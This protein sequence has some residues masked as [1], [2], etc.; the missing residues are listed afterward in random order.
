M[1]RI[2]FLLVLISLLLLK[3]GAAAPLVRDDTNGAY[4]LIFKGCYNGTGMG[5]VTPNFVTLRGDNLV[6][7]AGKPVDFTAQKLD[8]QNHRFHGAI[9]AGGTIVVISGRV[10]PSGGALKKARLICTFE[11]VGVGFG[12][13]AGEHN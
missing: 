9:S 1:K 11:A 5:M 3:P 10:D 12:R 7:E 2:A 8:V 13:V 4:R 6:D